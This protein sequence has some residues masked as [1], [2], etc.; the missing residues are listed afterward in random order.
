MS[1]ILLTRLVMRAAQ[2]M[3]MSKA[4]SIRSRLRSLAI[5]SPIVQR[6]IPV[7]KSYSGQ[8]ELFRS[9]RFIPV[10]KSYSGQK[11]LFRSLDLDSFHVASATVLAP[12]RDSDE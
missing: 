4:F 6:V 1:G 12:S 10:K 2:R 11:E 3:S 8:K 9:K 5:W 7:K